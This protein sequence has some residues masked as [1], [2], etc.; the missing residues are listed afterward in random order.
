MITRVTGINLV[1]RDLARDGTRVLAF[2]DLNVNGV[3]LRGCALVRTAKE[4]LA[5][6]PPRLDHKDARFGVGFIDSALQHA[7]LE[8]ARA[9]YSAVGGTDLPAW[10]QRKQRADASTASPRP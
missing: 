8:A 10:A 4:G 7:A 3:A 1:R 5:L 6:R 9:A 2:I